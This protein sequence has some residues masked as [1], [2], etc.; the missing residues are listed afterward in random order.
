MASASS[1]ADVLSVIIEIVCEA[2][3]KNE[4]ARAGVI[5]V[6]KSKGKLELFMADYCVCERIDM[7]SDRSRKLLL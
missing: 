3:D 5:N 2:S 7:K 1:T 4:E 6:S